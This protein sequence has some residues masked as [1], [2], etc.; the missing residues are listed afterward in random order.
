MDRVN[1]QEMS[2]NGEF[3]GYGVMCVVENRQYDSHYSRRRSNRH[4][5]GKDYIYTFNLNLIS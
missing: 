1:F 2:S 5:C 3:N 4:S